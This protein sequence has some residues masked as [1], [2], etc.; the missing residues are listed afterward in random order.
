MNAVD[1]FCGGH[2]LI[3]VPVVAI[4]HVH[5]LD[6]SQD[7]FRVVEVLREFNNEV[8]VDAFLNDRVDFY[9][10][11]ARLF[12]SADAF[13]YALAAMGATAHEIKGLVVNRVE[14]HG[15]AMQTGV[16]EALRFVGEEIAIGGEGEVVNAIDLRQF[17]DEGFEVP[18]QEGFTAGHADLGDAEIDKNSGEAGDFFKGEDFCFGK[19]FVL[20]AKNLGGHAIGTAEIAFVGDRN[21][22]VADGALQC[23]EEIGHFEIIRI[24]RLSTRVRDPKQSRRVWYRR[25][26]HQR[27][28]C[29][30]GFP[31]RLRRG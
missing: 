2:D 1:N 8:I 24:L 12:G 30:S 10:L 20:F 5:E 19:K 18:A 22:Q 29:A 25:F 6:K 23:V 16:F 4:A 26:R 9:I 7:V 3:H 21:T 11:K 27:S 28:G 31:L 14:A 17:R 15:E 13:E